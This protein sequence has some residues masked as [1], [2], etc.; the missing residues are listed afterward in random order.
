MVSEEKF[1][2]AFHS[3]PAL[4][5]INTYKKETFLDVNDTYCR[6]SGYRRKEI[7]GKTIFDLNLFK[8]RESFY[9]YIDMLQRD[10]RVGDFELKFCGKLGDIRTGSVSAELIRIDGVKHVITSMID[11]I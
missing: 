8:E 1:I 4:I 7:I 9:K 2:R 6:L 11:M 5:T 3:S 10:E